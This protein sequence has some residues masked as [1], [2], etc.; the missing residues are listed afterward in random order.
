[1]LETGQAGSAQSE[2]SG[3]AGPLRPSLGNE[4]L[5]AALIPLFVIS[6]VWQRLRLLRGSL[7]PQLRQ[8]FSLVGRKT[9]QQ[10]KEGQWEAEIGS[11][12]PTRH[13]SLGKRKPAK[14]EQGD[15]SVL[16]PHVCE[17]LVAHPLAVGIRWCVA[18][19]RGASTRATTDPA[20]P[21]TR[22]GDARGTSSAA[23]SLLQLSGVLVERD[24]DVPFEG[25]RPGP[26]L[27]DQ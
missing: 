27:V 6:P 23:V 10:T 12:G 22:I 7:L 15:P 13:R 25:V 14:G 3:E 2:R 16:Y 8:H 21:S 9:K 24:G 17:H 1:M 18:W 11:I 5:R 19:S 26:G 20:F 4:D